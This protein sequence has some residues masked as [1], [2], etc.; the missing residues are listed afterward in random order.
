MGTSREDYATL[1]PL[2][3]E[4]ALLLTKKTKSEWILRK[5]EEFEPY[6]HVTSG[7]ADVLISTAY[8]KP[9]R[10][11]VNGN[12]PR[13][14]DRQYVR[15]Y[16]NVDTG[17][18]TKWQEV[19]FSSISVAT[20]RGPEVIANEIVRRFLPD[21][22]HAVNAVRARILADEEFELARFENLQACAQTLNRVLNAPYGEGRRL[23]ER[24]EFSEYLGEACTGIRI[25]CKASA[26]DIDLK[27][28]N[29]T[30]GQAKKVLALVKILH[31]DAQHGI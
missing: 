28:D 16:E 2:V 9:A 31:A 14:K 4:V 10:L 23:E 27:L 18:G 5:N 29:L 12:T 3:Q 30:V 25:E 24:T 15:A 8:D 20:A 7:D 19:T 11:S 13:G 26:K 6:F 17:N 22:L 21:Y 1:L